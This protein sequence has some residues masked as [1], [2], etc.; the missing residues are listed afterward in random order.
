MYIFIYI[1]VLYMHTLHPQT[2]HNY[3][4]MYIQA[5][6]LASLALCCTRLFITY[7]HYA[8]R[9]CKQGCE[10]QTLQACKGHSM[11]HGTCEGRAKGID[12]VTS[13]LFQHLAVRYWALNKQELTQLCYEVY[14]DFLFVHCIPTSPPPP[15][16][17]PSHTAY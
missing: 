2:K 16:S 15:P 12:Y 1:H 4:Y 5:G 6:E 11:A 14:L 8:I 13:R 7:L 10:R 17:F 3:Y 9:C